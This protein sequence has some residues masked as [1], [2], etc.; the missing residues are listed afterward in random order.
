MQFNQPL[1]EH[2]NNSSNTRLTPSPSLPSHYHFWCLQTSNF[3]LR[4]KLS[5][6]TREVFSRP[7]SASRKEGTDRCS[8]SNKQNTLPRY[9]RNS[10]HH[11]WNICAGQ[12]EQ[13]C[14]CTLATW[15]LPTRDRKKQ[16]ANHWKKIWAVSE[17]RTSFHSQQK[18]TMFQWI[19]Q[20]LQGWRGEGKE[21][22][23]PHNY[24]SQPC[25]KN[26]TWP[27]QDCVQRITLLHHTQLYKKIH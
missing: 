4:S 15:E 16:Q 7:H 2:S 6:L 3:A 9:A 17:R 24:R 22:D 14:V 26:W 25:D 13:W 8:R 1:W 19:G 12:S 10:I 21:T 5:Q 18:M 11:H 23:R 27:S 20:I